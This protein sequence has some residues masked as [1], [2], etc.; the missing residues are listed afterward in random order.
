MPLGQLSFLVN[1]LVKNCDAK[2]QHFYNICKYF[3]L[4]KEIISKT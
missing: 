2:L 3:L 1:S 4:F